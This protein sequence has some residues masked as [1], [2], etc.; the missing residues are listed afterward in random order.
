[1]LQL[2][3]TNTTTNFK[4]WAW[5][6]LSFSLAIFFSSW[7]K[8]GKA[9]RSLERLCHWHLSPPIRELW[10]QKRKH[11]NLK[12]IFLFICHSGLNV[13]SIIHMKFFLSLTWCFYH[14]ESDFWQS[15]LI[16]LESAVVTL[17]LPFCLSVCVWWICD[18]HKTLCWMIIMMLIEIWTSIKELWQM[19]HRHLTVT[20][21]MAFQHYFWNILLLTLCSAPQLWSTPRTSNSLE[22][23]LVVCSSMTCFTNCFTVSGSWP[24]A[25]KKKSI[26]LRVQS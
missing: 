7:S 17:I 5:Q 15:L 26:Q 19:M 12:N 23:V 18:P 25:N 13:T 10:S 20:I 24:S 21:Q 14:P 8:D 1:M 9:V 11:Q 3:K 2:A 4:K 22:K 16:L 6:K